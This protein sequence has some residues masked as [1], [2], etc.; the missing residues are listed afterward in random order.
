VPRPWY[1]ELASGGIYTQSDPIGLA[2][3]INTYAYVGGNP[4][5]FVDPWG[6]CSCIAI[7]GTKEDL[8][9]KDTWWGG[10][11]RKV[12]GSYQC[13]DDDKKQTRVDK[14]TSSE[15]WMNPMRNDTGKEGNLIGQQYGTAVFNSYSMRY[16]YPQAGYASFNPLSSSPRSPELVSWARSC[17]CK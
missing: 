5:S 8:M 6:L 17:G 14:A 1:S 10:Q 15:W 12:S 11:T 16:T 7:S 13:T 4:I 9:A 2:G 3:G